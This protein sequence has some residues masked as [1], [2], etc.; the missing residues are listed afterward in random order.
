MA[1]SRQKGA[2]AE[3]VIKKEL[4]RL[5]GL[6]WQRVPASGALSAQHGLKGDL[7]IPQ[8]NM[9]YSVEAKHYKDDHL[10]SKLLTSKNP[11]LLE[12]WRQ[13]IRQA[14]QTDKEPLLIFKFDRS[15]MFVAYEQPIPNCKRYM[16]IYMDEADGEHIFYISM[17]QD[18][19]KNKGVKWTK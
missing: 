3:S 9:Y 19:C 2:R 16:E 12:W 7:Y 11:Q 1:D 10:T 5:T 17:L 18:F 13:A 6:N 4:I 14:K 8:T 15:K